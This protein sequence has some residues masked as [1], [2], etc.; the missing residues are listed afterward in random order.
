M[1]IIFFVWIRLIHTSVFS[2]MMLLHPL[3]PHL[4]QYGALQ[5]NRWSLEKL[6]TYLVQAR[7]VK[8]ISTETLRERCLRQAQAAT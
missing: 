6:M 5:N 3:A 8:K 7:I 1:T 2:G 4:C